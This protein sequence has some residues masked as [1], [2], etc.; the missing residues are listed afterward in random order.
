MAA[1]VR[2]TDDGT[3]PQG[4]AVGPLTVHVLQ[5]NL[6]EQYG[7]APELSPRDA[8]SR[9][10]GYFCGQALALRSTHKCL[11]V[12][13]ALPLGERVTRKL[14]FT[15][16]EQ[17]SLGRTPRTEMARCWMM[18]ESIWP[19]LLLAGRFN[20]PPATLK[21]AHGAM[22][23]ALLFAASVW[24]ANGWVPDPR[25]YFRATTLGNAV[26]NLIQAFAVSVESFQGRLRET[27]R[28]PR[29]FRNLFIEHPVL[30]LQG[31]SLLAPD[32][33]VL[34]PAFERLMTGR[35]LREWTHESGEDGFQDASR[36]I[37]AVFEDYARALLSSADVVLGGTYLPEFK[38]NNGQ[39]T[40]DSPD[41]FILRPTQ[42][43]V[44]EVKAT[45]FPFSVETLET[46]PGD[47]LTGWLCKVLGANADRGPL[48]Q[49]R[50]FFRHAKGL[51]PLNGADLSDA[52]YLVVTY[53][54][55]PPMLNW[56]SWRE[57]WLFN[58]EPSLACDLFHRTAFV[59]I[60]DLEA[61]AAASQCGE[62]VADL[63]AKWWATEYSAAP[64]DMD[65]IRGRL[66]DFCRRRVRNLRG[67]EPMLLR[68]ARENLFTA[69]EA[70]G[71][72][73]NHWDM[74]PTG[75]DDPAT[76]S[77]TSDWNLRRP[78]KSE[79]KNIEGY[80]RSIREHVKKYVACKHQRDRQ[81]I[82]E[83]IRDIQQKISRV[84]LHRS[85]VEG[86]WEDTWK[87]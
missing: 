63:V 2:S 30:Q 14:W 18:Y 34:F 56:K 81:L 65:E 85:G 82:R 37:G 51:G 77:W 17:D 57:K 80:R 78:A 19:Q 48:D 44:F 27:P 73:S 29:E 52:I 1:K 35:V 4:N 61:A 72:A 84:K 8:H 53:P 6:L 36:A 49:G 58:V 50:E 26:D 41:A 74:P 71:F 20:V 55:V 33:S 68:T 39:Q 13:R 76:A 60:A 70:A 32:P 67:Q 10:L 83:A 16:I 28:Y 11:Q 54:D 64:V 79:D 59:S 87:P 5:R 75:W 43:L 69:A 22:H 9:S 24:Q 42:S 46:S 47:H 45:R 3:F 62:N 15:A 86:S 40:V 21:T 25:Q 12:S 23:N 31:G 66:G 7:T 38:Y